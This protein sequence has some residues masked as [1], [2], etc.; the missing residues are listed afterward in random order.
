[1]QDAY[2]RTIDY[3]RISVT[4]RCNLRCIYCMPPEGVEL[5]KHEDILSLEEIHRLV[6]G[7]AKLGIKKVRVSGGEP[8]VRKGI[9]TLIAR[10]AATPGISEVTL[11]TNAILLAEHALELKEAGLTRVNIS[12]DSLNKQ[13]YSDIT[14]GGDLNRTWAGIQA[15]LAAGLNPVKINVVVMRGFNDQEL[16]S[17]IKLVFSLPLVIRFIELM[18]VGQG[19]SNWRKQYLPASEILDSIRN[20]YKITPVE[21]DEKGGPA[22]YYTLEGARGCFGIISPMS[23]MFCHQCNRIR[24][25]AD[26]RI[27]PCL[28]GKWELD[29]RRLMREGIG[30]EE[31]QK[32]IATA[33]R[34]KPLQHHFDHNIVPI[35]K[36]MSQIG[37]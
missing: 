30:E 21:D 37:G 4:D 32:L 5:K 31:L 33:I 18:P 3:L 11:T 29:I 12:M 14:R 19:A 6:A 9:S 26:G 35:P 10:I 24:I 25:S 34:H 16:T 20:I 2:G 27:R 13:K 8:L 17:F 28:E 7:A 23:N 1:M 15:A 22:R 36:W